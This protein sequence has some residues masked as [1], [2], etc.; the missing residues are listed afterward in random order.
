MINLYALSTV[1]VIAAITF[2]LRFLPFAIYNGNKELPP[3]IMKFGRILPY[4]IIGMLVVY[5]LKN[6]SIKSAAGFIPELVS[7]LVVAVLYI[8]KRN[9]LIS[10]ICGTLCYMFFVQIV[11]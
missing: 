3:I 6:V 10:I 2:I 9:T 4:A 11:F 5:C 7:C 8:W 1:A